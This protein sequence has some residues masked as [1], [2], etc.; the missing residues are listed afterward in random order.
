M[1]AFGKFIFLSIVA[2]LAL[3][4]VSMCIWKPIGK[5]SKKNVRKFKTNLDEVDEDE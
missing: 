1:F 4:G 2:L 5:V 3:F